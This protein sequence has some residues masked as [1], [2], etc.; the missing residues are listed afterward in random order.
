MLPF[1]HSLFGVAPGNKAPFP[2]SSALF[3]NHTKV[4]YVTGKAQGQRVMYQ[5]W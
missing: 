5:G 4:F 1:C 3:I 2:E